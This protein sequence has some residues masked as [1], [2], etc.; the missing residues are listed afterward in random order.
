M[1][2]PCQST[3][4][5]SL[6]GLEWLAGFSVSGAKRK[7]LLVGAPSCEL[8]GATIRLGKNKTY[9]TLESLSKYR[10]IQRSY[11]FRLILGM[12]KWILIQLAQYESLFHRDYVVEGFGYEPANPRTG[13]CELVISMVMV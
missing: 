6:G 7:P 12:C 11:L 8:H 13:L 10:R 4:W 5:V 9:V 2:D 1:G 3:N